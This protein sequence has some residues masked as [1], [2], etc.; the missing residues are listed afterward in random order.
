MG[1]QWGVWTEFDAGDGWMYYHNEETKESVWEMPIEVRE[2]LGEM[3][4]MM[5]TA[6]AFSGEWGAFDAGF[7]TIYYFHLSTHQSSWE[8]PKEWGQEREMSYAELAIIQEKERAAA[9]AAEKKQ[10]TVVGPPTTPTTTVEEETTAET[11]EERAESFK[12]IEAFRQ[13]LRE[14]QIMPFTRWEAAL[15]RIAIDERFRAIPSMDERRAI[16]EHFV[17]HR[18]AE[19][20]KE[21]KQNMKA[22]RKTFLHGLAQALDKFPLDQ[23]SKK[24]K[25]FDAFMTWFK[26]AEPALLETLAD[27]Q[28]L[29]SLSEQ[30]KVYNKKLDEWHPV[31]LLRHAEEK[32]LRE[33]FEDNPSWLKDKEWDESMVMPALLERWPPAAQEQVFLACQATMRSVEASK[34]GGGLSKYAPQPSSTTTMATTRAPQPQTTL[35]H[36]EVDADEDLSARGAKRRSP[37]R[38]RSPVGRHRRDRSR[39]RS[40]QR[41]H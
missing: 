19:L 32:K 10:A 36:Q 9:A 12:R 15:P 30:E 4:A 11:E 41:R 33:H 38:S 25:S 16:F 5:K 7:G 37:S 27:V 13:M 2:E 31:A 22:M 20:A 34:S 35:R 29:M 17:K 26:Q 14:K 28:N 40:R 21:S 1:R 39:S 24:K 6:L 23:V 3:Q 18:K 8:R